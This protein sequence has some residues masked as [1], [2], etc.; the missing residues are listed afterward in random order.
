TFLHSREATPLREYIARNFEINEICLFPDDVFTFSDAESVVVVG[1]RLSDGKRSITKV[2]Y[3]RVREADI[4][5]FKRNYQVTT[6]RMVLA[7]DFLNTDDRSF[8]IP[9]L[10]EVWQHCHDYPKIGQV[11]DVGQGLIY[12]SVGDPALPHGAITMSAKRRRGLTKGFAR[13]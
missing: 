6:S 1:R 5:H 8:L 13:M 12:R 3:K 10:Q 7:A 2:A 11:A 9:D 4:D